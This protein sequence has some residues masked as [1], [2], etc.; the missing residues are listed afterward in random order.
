MNRKPKH[1]YILRVNSSK[2]ALYVGSGT[3]DTRAQEHIDIALGKTNVRY[4]Q[5]Q[6]ALY[7]RIRQLY[8]TNDSVFIEIVQENLTYDQ[9]ITLE[10]SLTMLIGTQ[11]DG[12]G[13]LY[14]IKYG[15]KF[16][17]GFR[18]GERNSFYGKSH[19]AET[20]EKLRNSRSKSWNLDED[21]KRKMS[22]N[23]VKPTQVKLYDKDMNLIDGFPTIKKCAEYLREQHPDKPFSNSRVNVFSK[24]RALIN[25]MYY[26]IRQS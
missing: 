12:N 1:V 5:E 21:T 20:L 16:P 10:E 9:A 7:E 23:H 4:N 24:D 6:E 14:N 18:E 15:N 11:Y 3:Y 2:E 26:V 19:S 13:P 25:D 8:D 22:E 17:K